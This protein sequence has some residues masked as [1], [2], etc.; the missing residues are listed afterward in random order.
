ML[1]KE[2]VLTAI[3]ECAGE[4]GRCPTLVDLRKFKK[5][6]LRALRRHFSGYTQA[7]REA[8]LDPQG[9]GHRLTLE[10]LFADWAQVTRQLGKIPSLAD[11]ENH[12]RHSAGPLLGRFGWWSEVPQ[13][14]L[15]FAQ[16]NN[17]ESEWQDVLELIRTQER[18]APP[19]KRWQA[20][21]STGKPLY[22]PPLHAAPLA[23]APTNE[24]GVVYLFGALAGELGFTVTRMQQ[25]FPDCE[26]MLQVGANRWQRLRLEF[27]Y[28]SRNFL[29]H[30]HDAQSCDL[31]VCW[32]HNWPECPE[33]LDVLDLSAVV[34][35][36]ARSGS[37]G[38]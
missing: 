12:G 15:R 33:N 27:E 8:G 38:E 35:P 25:E 17:L 16:E 26:A 9:S 28:E 29:V 5:I 31:I 36:R 13:G 23:H 21:L 18:P 34:L 30:R 14:L 3:R 37:Q 6:G 24:M 22:G 11:Y 10:A 7:L 19:L 20:R 1:S 4:V 32:R 2:A